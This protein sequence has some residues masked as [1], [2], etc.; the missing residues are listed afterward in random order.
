MKIK[1]KQ[2]RVAFSNKSCHWNV[3]LLVC[4]NFPEQNCL[5]KPIFNNVSRIKYF[6]PMDNTFTNKIKYFSLSLALGPQIG[7][8]QKW[9]YFL[10]STLSM[11]K[12]KK[13]DLNLVEKNYSS[14]KNISHI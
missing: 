14:G 4:N 8:K 12:K 6:S 5:D 11:K 10:S 7:L 13:T 3:L 2:R 9:H 1:S